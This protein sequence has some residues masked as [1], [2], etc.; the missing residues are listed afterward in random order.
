MQVRA[1]SAQVCRAHETACVRRSGLAC[2]LVP[3][4]SAWPD[5]V[6]ILLVVLAVV[7]VVSVRL[8]VGLWQKVNAWRAKERAVVHRATPNEVLLTWISEG[9]ELAARCAR[10]AKAD[11]M[12][13]SGVASWSEEVTSII[14][15]LRTARRA[16]RE[17][18][19]VRH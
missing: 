19:G 12:H 16:T 2:V 7:Y 11:C 5:V 13:L 8:D 10:K 3:E 9:E 1:P 14:E 17:T 18:H 4:S 15:T 6:L